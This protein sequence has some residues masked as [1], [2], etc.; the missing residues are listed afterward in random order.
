MLTLRRTALALVVL[1]PALARAQMIESTSWRDVFDKGYPSLDVLAR[2]EQIS[3]DSSPSLLGR[4]QGRC[5][6]DV[7]DTV[8]LVG[9]AE[10]SRG[11]RR[12]DLSFPVGER[13]SL[14]IRAPRSPDTLK[15]RST[16]AIC[17][18]GG[19]L[20]SLVLEHG[21]RYVH[22]EVPSPPQA[23]LL[24]MFVAGPDARISELR[25]SPVT[26]RIESFAQARSRWKA[27]AWRDRAIDAVLAGSLYV[28][29]LPDMVREV[30]GE[31]T[32]VN[33]TATAR[34]YVEQWVYGRSL[35]VYVQNGRVTAWQSF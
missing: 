13:P 9:L 32:R 3:V 23:G 10:Y 12:W 14:R 16:R 15:V 26:K 22:M 25:W 35:F 33:Q 30:F 6:A 28:G 17:E 18:L 7:P 34:S 29:M 24:W 4:M 21:G 20:H 27:A 5:V 11:E 2:V 31:P 1:A 19:E 8:V